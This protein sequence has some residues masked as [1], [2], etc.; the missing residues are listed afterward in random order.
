M[1]WGSKAEVYEPE[2]LRD[3]IRTEAQ[4]VLEKYRGRIEEKEESYRA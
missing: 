4:S 2:S 1:S 3:E